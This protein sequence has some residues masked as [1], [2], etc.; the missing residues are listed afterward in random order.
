M[1]DLTL[2]LPL[3]VQVNSGQKTIISC[4]FCNRKHSVVPAVIKRFSLKDF[5]VKCDCKKSFHVKFE[6]TKS[7]IHDFDVTVTNPLNDHTF[8]NINIQ[9]LNENHLHFTSK[10]QLNIRKGQKLRVS[11]SFPTPHIPCIQTNATVR[12]VRSN[13]VS[14]FFTKTIHL[15]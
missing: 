13:F 12:L 6:V 15:P 9:L 4:P 10:E 5:V 2:L 8:R 3:K 11:I 7:S 14:C 1:E